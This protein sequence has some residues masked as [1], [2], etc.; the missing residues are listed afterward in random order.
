MAVLAALDTL[1]Y[2]A[3]NEEDKMDVRELLAAA[4]IIRTGTS[5]QAPF[6]PGT[7]GDPKA[8]GIIRTFTRTSR[9]TASNGP[10]K[11]PLPKCRNRRSLVPQEVIELRKVVDDLKK[12]TKKLTTSS[13]KSRN[14]WIAKQKQTVG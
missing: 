2:I 11:T 9:E 8:I 13:T 3:R 12:D 5:G 14:V 10:P 7:L 1:A 4:S 6:V